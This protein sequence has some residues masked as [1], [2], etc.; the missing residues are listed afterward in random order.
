MRTITTK[1]ANDCRKCGKPLS[2]GSEAVYERHIGIFCPPCGP[3]DPEEI[4]FW[5][6]ETAERRA[7][8]YE[9]WAQKRRAKA[10]ALEA[11][12]EPYRG[13][14]AFNT[15]PGH[16]PERARAIARSEKAWEHSSTARRFE[17][18]ASSLRRVR[19]AGD[20]ERA[21]Q[22]KREEV[23]AW[24]GIGMTIETGIYGRGIVKKINRKTAT[25]SQTGTSGAYIVAVDLS[26]LSPVTV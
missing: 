16:I 10:A 11:R 6:T 13:D 8:Q 3:T 2:V 12:N 22:A 1:Y 19:V 9:E 26:F 18:K 21:R 20:A 17:E 15:Q 5:R 25:I 4:R 23:R 24:L 7:G 14:I